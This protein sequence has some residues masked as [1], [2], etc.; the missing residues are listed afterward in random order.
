MGA[1]AEGAFA[2]VATTVLL[3]LLIAVF[4]ALHSTLADR[5]RELHEKE[6]RCQVWR[7]TTEHQRVYTEGLWKTMYEAQ[8]RA[9]FHDHT[10][11]PR[12]LTEPPPIPDTKVTPIHRQQIP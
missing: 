6:F 3:A 2:I 10:N 8:V 9:I 12:P 11:R 5:Y 1:D 4:E 7:A